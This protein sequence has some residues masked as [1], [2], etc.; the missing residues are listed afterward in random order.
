EEF[1]GVVHFKGR[2]PG[3]S[4]IT[5]T[6]RDPGGLT[7][8]LSFDVTVVTG[9]PNRAP[10]LS[11]TIPDLTDAAIGSR[12]SSSL[13]EVFDDPDYDALTYTT[14]NSNPTVASVETRNDS[15]FVSALAGGST[16]MSV[17]ATDP[18]GLSA[19]DSWNVTV[20]AAVPETFD[21]DLAFQGSFTDAQVRHIEAAR[22]RWESILA[23]TEL[24]DITYNREVSC[25]GMT[26]HAGTVDD[27]LV[28]I[29]A[30]HIDGDG[31]TLGEA[32]YCRIRASD[33]TP[34]IS[35]VKLDEDD[36]AWVTAGGSLEDLVFHE[37]G[38]GLGF[39]G[40]YWNLKGLRQEGT[41]PHFTGTLAR[42]AFDAA[43]GTSYTGNK[44]PAASD[45][46]HWREP[47]FGPEIMTPTMTVGE[48]QPISA[49]TLQAMVDLGYTV[50]V[51]LA[52]DYDLPSTTPPDPAPERGRIL[53]LRNDVVLGPVMIDGPDGRTIRIIPP[54]PG[55][56]QLPP[57][58]TRE[59][60]IETR[61]P[62]VDIPDPGS[63]RPPTGPDNFGRRDPN[64]GSRPG[65]PWIVLD[66]RTSEP[67]PNRVKAS[68]GARQR[69]G[70][71]SLP[72]W[73]GSRSP[74]P[75]PHS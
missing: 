40:H 67:W 21:I 16:S 53:D 72:P 20:V 15:V 45:L 55:S 1:E 60:N 43:G 62:G 36:I 27:H 6:A 63:L 68:K 59:A 25:L 70:T 5:V 31:G 65:S 13:S 73:R 50:D 14:T 10:R 47:V 58:P 37:I 7:A 19:T 26:E 12:Y 66:R 30:S 51:S 71:A 61:P 32:V 33:D 35:G 23:A 9:L 39:L 75:L 17:T 54:P 42:A 29:I 41:D 38:H 28:L 74:W 2:E 48:T 57:G 8:T 44:V 46:N 22:D 52:E 69:A 18:G 56:R 24:S 3:R 49:I 11:S 4:T 64:P 34:I